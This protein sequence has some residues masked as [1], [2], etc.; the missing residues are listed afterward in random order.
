M[1]DQSHISAIKGAIGKR[2]TIRFRNHDETFSDL[3]GVL[4]SETSLIDRDGIEHTFDPESIAFIR[5]IPVFNR[6]DSQVATLSIYDTKSRQVKEVSHHNGIVHLYCCGP[7]VYRDAHV[8]NLRTFL[9]SDLIAR[10]L[11]LSGLEVR[12]IQ[13]ITDVGHMSDDFREEDKVLS[14]AKS[15]KVDPYVI[16]REFEEKFHNDLRLLNIIPSNE[17]PRASDA[18]ASMQ[19]VIETLIE[20]KNAYLG[21]DGSV[22]FD[23]TSY[24]SYGAISGNKL[25]ALKPGHR[26]EYRGDDGK[27]FHAD[28]A[29][30]KSAG[31]RSEMIWQS[32]WGT[33]F[34]G[35]HIEC[36][37]MSTDLLDARVD[38]HIGGIDLR[39]PHHENERAQSNALTGNEVVDTWVHGE[40]LLF[41]GRK[42]SKS[43]GNVLL[44]SEIA[45]A[46]MDPLALRLVFLENRYRSQMDLTWDSIKAAHITL[47]RWREL[48]RNSDGDELKFDQEISTALTSDLD[49]P[50]A[51]L[52]LRAIEK[53]STIGQQDKRAI[54]LFADQVLGL[55]LNRGIDVRE[56]SEEILALLHKRVSARAEK[57]W[58]ESDRLREELASLGIEVADSPEGQSWRWS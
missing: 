43:S 25:E 35:W 9:L 30:W 18:I 15:K 7:T 22:Y 38:I 50:R 44:L 31:E 20:K 53:D 26:Y 56:A 14:E 10:T 32:P 37:A 49:T 2:A 46:G 23:A 6:R 1:A 33:G 12:S 54:F 28:W 29:L 13:N 4:H 21:S 48:V 42:M 17:Y 55:E 47:R 58:A 45:S 11:R 40:H 19:K 16:A 41:E 3:I 8:G 57:N 34:P 39:F 24:P 27:R 36:T 52:R 51:M 5:V